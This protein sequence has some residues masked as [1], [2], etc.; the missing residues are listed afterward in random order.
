MP[1]SE[2]VTSFIRSTFRS[3]WAF[4]LACF[5]R[6]HRDRS[7]AAANLVSELRASELVVGRSVELLLAAGLVVV[8]DGGGAR[9]QPASPSLD[10]LFAASEAL[11]ARSPDAVRRMIVGRGS[12]GLAAFA[13]AFRIWKD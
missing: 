11:Y 3:V 1:G 6:S 10:A 2:E 5:L 9:Y 12:G 13:D 8:D 7:W 4:E